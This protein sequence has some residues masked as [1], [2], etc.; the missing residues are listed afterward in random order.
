MSGQ[1]SNEFRAL[2]EASEWLIRLRAEPDS[3]EAVKSW[4]RWCEE[5]PANA[6]AFERIQRLWRQMDHL[7]DENLDHASHASIQHAV[8]SATIATL[9]RPSTRRSRWR[10][11]RLAATILFAISASAGW[12]ALKV[13]TRAVPLSTANTQNHVASLP[14][15]SLVNLAGKT[16]VVVNFAGRERR[17]RMSSGEAFFEVHPD[18]TR[19]FVVRAGPLDVTAV[20]TEFDVKSEAGRVS[21][22]VAEG[23]VAVQPVRRANANASDAPW[24]IG[25][26]Y[27]FIYSD[28]SGS[29]AL[30]SV[31]TSSVLAWREGRL[32]YVNAP[33]TQVIA[34]VSRYTHHPVE[35]ADPSIGK[36]TFTG[37]VFTD[38]T[39]AW[40]KAL[41]GVLPVRLQSGAA[42]G[43]VIVRAASMR[44]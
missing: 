3:E 22:T 28:G 25:P 31:N 33:L 9:L 13:R 12:Y 19:P 29:T 14:D 30:T 43:V 36:L 11:W 4:I 2:G 41:P 18:K 7:A 40:L 26:G 37:T 5:D 38:S 39:D 23:V 8:H 17:L 20:G 24:R 6:T 16:F 34:D 32:D 44:H 15:G 42:G 27:Q 1:A 10:D 21:V 35:I